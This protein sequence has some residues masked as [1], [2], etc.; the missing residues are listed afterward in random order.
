MSKTGKSINWKNINCFKKYLIF[1][2]YCHTI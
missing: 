1:A 2:R